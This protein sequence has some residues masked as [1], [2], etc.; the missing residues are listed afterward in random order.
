MYGAGDEFLSSSGF[1]QYEDSGIGWRHLC[2]LRQHAA[3][4]FRRPNDL[5]EH[6]RTVDFFAQHEIFILRP[7]LA[8]FAIVDVGSRC[9]P[10]HEFFLFVAERVVTDEE[11]TILAILSQRSLFDFKRET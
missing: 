7:F 1:A 4:W 8:A 9:I 3:K 10:T 2:H 11:P 5:F 6:R